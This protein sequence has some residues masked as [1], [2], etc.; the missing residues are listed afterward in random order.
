MEPM[1]EVSRQSERLNVFISYSRDDL[2]FSDQLDHA[3][4]LTGFDTTIDRLGISG[5][6]DW[7]SRLG[8]L[9]RDSDT[10]AFVLSPSSAVS[11]ICAWEVEEAIRLGKRIIP[12][13]CRPLEDVSP[14]LQLAELN[15]IFFYEEPK[16]PG[17]GF[18]SGLVSLVSALNTDL[19]WL[20]E[21][22]R[23]LRRASE[24][25]A[26][27]RSANRLL[28]GADVESA[29]EWAARRP[30]EAPEP[31]AL[32]LDFIKA[33]EEE[34]DRRQSTEA[35]RLRQIADAQAAQGKALEEKEAAQKRE[36][37]QSRRVVKRTQVGLAAAVVLAV[38]AGWFGFDARRQKNVAEDQRQLAQEQAE[39]AKTALAQ[40]LAERAWSHLTNGETNRAIR[41][42]VSGWRVAPSNIAHYRAPLARTLATEI[43][44]VTRQLHQDQMTT[45]ALSPDGVYA[46]SGGQDGLAV[47]IN[48]ASLKVVRSFEHKNQ[49]VSAAAIDP[50]G[51]RVL[52][53]TTDGTIH[54]WEIKTGNKILAL[55]GHKSRVTAASFSPDATR[56]LTASFDRTA[57]LWDLATGRELITLIGHSSWVSTALFSPDGKLLVTGSRDG[58]ARLWDAATGQSMAVLTGHKGG[59]TA[60]AYSP[61]GKSVLT[62]SE[63]KTVRIWGSQGELIALLKGHEDGI[64]TVSMSPDGLNAYVID[65]R[66]NAYI[67][68]SKTSRIV[69]AS[70]SRAKG[71]GLAIF[72]HRGKYAAISEKSRV[73][74]VWDADAA[75]TLL[76]LSR[77]N[78]TAVSAMLWSEDRLYIGDR[79]GLLS[80]YDLSAVTRSMNE[81]VTRACGKERAL[82][83]HFTWME[84]ASDPLIREVWD[85]KGTA[86]SVCVST[87]ETVE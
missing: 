71:V 21:H 7:K 62:G 81:L 39:R 15:Y 23:Y 83:P 65:Y 68:D 36:A 44:P 24:W 16:S 59:V 17:S 6:E 13:L 82:S 2:G 22:T 87:K 51:R 75:R 63:D 32:Q 67:W 3:L 73:L 47:L 11:E 40:V 38:V 76:E 34:E 49:P 57:R 14:P 41:Y 56:L 84:S 25:D 26:G 12:V 42:A 18:G 29:K 64:R 78:S 79:S 69:V 86:R 10:V 80:V 20:R 9:I 61:D 85:P 70:P 48:T 43:I 28:S 33:S 27:G 46:I 74:R 54:I 45:L 19:D 58:T 30:K 50:S 60:I 4:G 72:A 31:T 1:A 53:I 37:V 66:G 52:T 5:G 35:Q 77:V 8:N 55:K